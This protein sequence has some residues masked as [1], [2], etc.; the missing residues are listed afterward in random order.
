LL[1]FHVETPEKIMRPLSIRQSDSAARHAKPSLSSQTHA[2]R[3]P[4]FRSG[5]RVSHQGQPCTVDYVVVRRGQLLVHLQETNSRV[6]ADK[7][8]LEPT[9]LLLQ[10]N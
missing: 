3:L 10:R 6:D 4:L 7:L 2:V 9:Q 5:T 1:V 8:S